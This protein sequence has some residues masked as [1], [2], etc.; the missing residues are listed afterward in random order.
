M[1]VRIW[2]G[3]GWSKRGWGK[4]QKERFVISIP[5]IIY[6]RSSGEA[7]TEITNG[8][9]GADRDK[10]SNA[11]VQQYRSLPAGTVLVRYHIV[12]PLDILYYRTV[13]CILH[14]SRVEATVL[15]HTIQEAYITS[16]LIL[17]SSRGKGIEQQQ[18]Q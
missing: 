18:Q 1:V 17:S 14:C 10:K 2:C 13:Q 16:S 12:V 7:G 15:V 6:A 9:R 8:E 11:A 4:E 3:S 5:R